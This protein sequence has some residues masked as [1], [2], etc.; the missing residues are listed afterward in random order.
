MKFEWHNSQ[1]LE[2][3]ESADLANASA[4][5]A[6]NGINSV[7]ISGDSDFGNLLQNSDLLDQ[8]DLYYCKLSV[9]VSITYQLFSFGRE[10]NY[11]MTKLF[12]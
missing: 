3:I 10:K 9:Y 4:A 7:D 1:W 2:L 12:S 8:S 6:A 11:F 5:A